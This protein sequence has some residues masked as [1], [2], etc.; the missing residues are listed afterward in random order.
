MNYKKLGLKVGLEIHQQLDTNKLFCDCP[1]K[2]RKDKPDIIVK[3]ELRP[4]PGETGVIDK[5]ALYEKKKKKFYIYEAYS[6]TNCLVELDEEPPHKI[7]QEALDVALIIAKML[8]CDIPE[9]VQVMRKTVVDGSNT[10]GF[11]RT[12]LI[13]RNGCLETK[14][15]KI[16]IES[17]CLEEDAGRRT[18]EDK[19]SVTF[20]LDRLGIP[21]VEIATA[22]DI[23]TPNQ[24]REVAKKL[25]N[26]LR[27]T[28]KVKRGIGTIRQDLNVS[29]KK[30]ARVEIK[31]VQDLKSMPKIVVKEIERQKSVVDKK[32]K[33]DNAVRNVKSD[34]TTKYLRP[35]P[36][37]ARMYPETDLPLIHITQKRLKSLVLPET[38]EEKQDKLEKLG[39]NKDLAKQIISIGRT[40]DFEKFSKKYSK[41]NST[42]IATTLTSSAKEVKRKL[43]LDKFEPS[44]EVL[45]KLFTGLSG[46]SKNIPSI[47]K[48]SILDILL[49]YGKSSKN[50]VNIMKNYETLSDK[51]LEKEVNKLLKKHKD[52]PENKVKGIIIGQLK[53][54]ASPK[55]IIQILNKK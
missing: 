22:P 9:Y 49:E 32:K 23:K 17:I 51:E 10:S 15:G 26:L 19:E 39:L 21:L 46:G 27:A 6:D 16:G 5:A 50:I 47:S 14:E 4:M 12:A 30:G 31:G 44:N 28:G 8:N 33:V 41:V 1:C 35:M 42:L 40:N 18:A 37:A 36:G 53:S 55:K 43:K 20:R 29:I 48:E 38:H 7:N 24:A 45:D 2:I 3:R 34:N 11:Q 52:A 25:G 54:K 13:A